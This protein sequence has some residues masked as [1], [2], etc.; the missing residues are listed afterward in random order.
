MPFFIVIPL[1]KNESICSEYFFAILKAIKNIYLSRKI[2]VKNLLFVICY[3][4]QYLYPYLSDIVEII[5]YHKLI[6][7][8]TDNYV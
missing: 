3:V 2:I 5:I 8:P 4:T 6:Q 1:E 7:E